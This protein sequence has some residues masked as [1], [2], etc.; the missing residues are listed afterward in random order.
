MGSRIV[1]DDL[2]L[3]SVHVTP[4]R[5]ARVPFGT[6]NKAAVPVRFSLGLMTHCGALGER[7]EKARS[8]RPRVGSVS[9]LAQWAHR[10]QGEGR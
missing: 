1:L 5:D 10:R 2:D 4:R 8:A 3:S 7:C 6:H 9:R